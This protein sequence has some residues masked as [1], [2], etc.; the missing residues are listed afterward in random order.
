[1]GKFRID[2]DSDKH[3]AMRMIGHYLRH[4]FFSFS[5]KLRSYPP[6]RMSPYPTSQMHAAQKRGMYPMAGHHH[7]M[8]PTQN[9]PGG[10]GGVGVGG[11]GGGGGANGMYSHNQQNYVPAP[12]MHQGYMRPMNNY[13]RGGAN[14]MM[15]Q[16]QRPMVAQYNMA[17]ASGPAATAA[18]AG[19]MMNAVAGHQSQYGYNHSG[20]NAGMNQSGY[21]N[22]QGYVRIHFTRP[23]EIS[24]S[25]HFILH[26]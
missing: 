13:G 5:L 26:M 16:Q 7:Q 14:A 12:P 1:M 20:Q 4:L 23:F 19:N 6:R 18:S 9:V 10:S 15:S 2:Y 21:Q 22:V 8:P 25:R 3:C 24:L 17:Q 11:G